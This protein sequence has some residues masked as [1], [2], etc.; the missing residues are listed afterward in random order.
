MIIKYY[1][2]LPNNNDGHGPVAPDLI[3]IENCENVV[4]H[5]GIFGSDETGP[6]TNVIQRLILL[7][8]NDYL[9]Q[10]IPPKKLITFRKDGFVQRLEVY[11]TA[12]VCN[13]DGKTVEKVSLS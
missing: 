11:G 3:I 8:N 5:G 13:D 12:Y 10:D 4:V 2:Y 9:M 7:D 6:N 1:T